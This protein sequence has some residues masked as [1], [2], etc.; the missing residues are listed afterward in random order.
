[1]KAEGRRQGRGMESG[2]IGV[3]STGALGDPASRGLRRT[4]PERQAEDLRTGLQHECRAPFMLFSRSGAKGGFCS[5]SLERALAAA[6]FLVN[7]IEDGAHRQVHLRRLK[8][9]GELGERGAGGF[10]KRPALVQ[11]TGPSWSA[12]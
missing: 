5:T 2:A 9:G 10:W 11:S 8:A 12:F 7:G 1:M 6:A 4:G 3:C